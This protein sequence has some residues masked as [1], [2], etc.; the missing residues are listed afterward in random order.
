MTDDDSNVD[1]L[2]AMFEGGVGDGPS[3]LPTPAQRLSQAR[4][5]RRRRR[6]T[7]A[8]AASAAVLV[9]GGV[10]SVLLDQDSGGA[11]K[12]PA[13]ATNAPAPETTAPSS[14]V[15]SPAPRD[16]PTVY[17]DTADQ[18]LV[19]GQFPAAYD[20]DGNLVVQRGWTV[21]RQVD[22]PY[23]LQPPQE[24]LGLVMTKGAHTRWML[25][26]RSYGLK[27]NGERLTSGTLGSG[28][29]ADDA[30]VAYSSFDDWLAS[31]M[32][33][34]GGPAVSPLLTVDANDQL[35]PGSG[36]EI[37]STRTMPVVEGYSR[38]GDRMVEVRRDGR[39]WF[40]IVR[41]HRGRAD[42]IPVDADVLSAPT[43]AALLN[44][45]RDQGE[46]GLR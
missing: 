37:V 31:E 7:T 21:A 23:G 20:R 12:D 10:G 25:I 14:A 16:D 8:V 34:N 3:G 38:A 15:P 39:A 36:V 17:P 1:L 30:G 32:A 9:V 4:R 5:V 44:H 41:G 2:P 35:H 26:D 22:N 46:G 13:S 42:V 27:D 28:A 40:A 24:S 45:L 6:L 18:Q 11:A 43:F 29:A 33:I 19:D